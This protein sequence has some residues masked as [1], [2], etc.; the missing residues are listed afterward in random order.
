MNWFKRLFTDPALPKLTDAEVESKAQAA[1]T[2]LDI[3]YKDA[4]WG[5]VGPL[6]LNDGGRVLCRTVELL[7]KEASK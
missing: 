3:G 7:F 6:Q 2:R 4:I 1:A 5:V